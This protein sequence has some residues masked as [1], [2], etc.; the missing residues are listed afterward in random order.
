MHTLILGFDAFDPARF[1]TLL[2][3]GELPNLARLS[4]QGAYRRFAVANPPQSEVSWTSIATGLDPGG[5]GIFDFVHRNPARYELQVSLLPTRSGRLGTRFVPPHSAYTIFEHAVDQGYPATAVWWPASFPARLE[6]PVRVLPGLGVPD[7]Q[8]RLG[9]GTLFSTEVEWQPRERKTALELLSP[10]GPGRYRAQLRGPQKKTVSGVQQAALDLQLDMRTEGARLVVGKQRLKLAAGT[11]SPIVE[12][13]F[14]MGPFVGVRA[15]TRF[16][17]TRMEP[18]PRLYALPLQIHPLRSPW[19]YAAPP[20][21]AKST[22]KRNGPFLTLGWPQD[23]T[24]LEEGCMSDEQFLALC[25]SIFET[26]RRILMH[27]LEDFPEGLLATVFDTLDRIQHMFWRDRPDIVDSW[28]RKL[29]ALLGQVQDRLARMGKRPRL[30]VVSDHGFAPFDQKVHLNRWLIEQGY[31]VAANGAAGDLKEVHWPQ[32]R[33]Y[34][35]GL[36]SLYLNL[37]DREGQGC[38]EPGQQKELAAEIRARLENWRGPDGRRIV[39]RVATR[40]E[41]FSGPLAEYGPDL[42]VGYAPGCRASAETGLGAWKE[43]PLTENRDHWGADHCI[44]P[45]AVPGVLLA[46]EGLTAYAR[47]TFRDFPE[48]AVGASLRGGPTSAPPDWGEEDQ[49]AVE[50]RLKG[51]GYL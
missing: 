46:S 31:L 51:L 7:I 18:A 2:E 15:L 26:R 29:D 13:R 12:L 40:T 37:Q 39:D 35:I 5:H 48:L 10:A 20:G 42:V 16:L 30:I 41:A 33:A 36:N 50:E 43:Q 47:P 27:H 3:A 45:Q 32:S 11:W 49:Q 28:Y 17:L 8:G 24:G 6:S 23:T 25:D 14:A 19:P 21:F 4:S 9:V 34:A 38:V 22:W 44:S 1:E